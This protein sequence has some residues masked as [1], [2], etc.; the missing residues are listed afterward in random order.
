MSQSDSTLHFTLPPYTR[1]K[2]RS[3]R[4]EELRMSLEKLAEKLNCDPRTILRYERGEHPIPPDFI[5]KVHQLRE[6]ELQSRARLV[7][8]DRI[9]ISQV[10]LAGLKLIELRPVIQRVDKLFR[11]FI[12]VPEEWLLAGE[13]RGHPGHS[14]PAPAPVLQAEPPGS[15]VAPAAAGSA[16]TVPLHLAKG[17]LPEGTVLVETVLSVAVET[18]ENQTRSFS[19]VR[20]SAPPPDPKQGQ[21]LAVAQLSPSPTPSKPDRRRSV[22]LGMAACLACSL[23][24]GCLLSHRV[25]DEPMVQEVQESI[26]LPETQYTDPATD[27]NAAMGEQPKRSIKMPTKPY[28]WQQTAPCEAGE[29]EIE[30]GCWGRMDP[31]KIRPPCPSYAVESENRC[32]VP[33]PAKPKKPNTVQPKQ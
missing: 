30:G 15:S 18:S 23:V 5:R 4:E 10:F 1:E 29:D 7:A 32:Y 11:M 27:G 14:P 17:R 24:M 3:V 22:G 19:A 6:E 31:A 16:Q 8:K 13:E 33:V 28:P 12:A 25:P 9:D 2:L 20:G 21:T 26:R